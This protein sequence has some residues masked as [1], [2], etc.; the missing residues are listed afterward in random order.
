MYMMVH[1]QEG[2]CQYWPKERGVAVSY[3]RF[4]VKMVYEDACGDYTVRK[5]ELGEESP[6]VMVC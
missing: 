4:K 3:G 5:F 2:C 1:M 6:Y